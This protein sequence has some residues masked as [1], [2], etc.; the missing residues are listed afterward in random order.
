MRVTVREHQYITPSG[1]ANLVAYLYQK[2]LMR[3]LSE[4]SYWPAVV[5]GRVKSN[6][7]GT[8]RSGGDWISCDVPG[9]ACTVFTIRVPPAPVDASADGVAENGAS[10]AV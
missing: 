6:Q 2:G 5:A 10:E 1:D 9:G 7:A 8:G 4:A 3:N